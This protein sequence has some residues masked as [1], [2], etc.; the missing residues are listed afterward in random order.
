MDFIPINKIFEI[1]V[2]TKSKEN[3]IYFENDLIKVKVTE[4]PEDGKANKAIIK[5]F[6]E[7]LKIPKSNIE[8]VSGFT[9]SIK[10]LIINKK[11]L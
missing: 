8:I 4:I 7:K 11:D 2:I 3:K 6:S 1:K 9:N 5:L 10:K